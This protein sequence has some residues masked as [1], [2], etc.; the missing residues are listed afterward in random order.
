M[1]K[2][3]FALLVSLTSFSAVAE[4][5]PLKLPATFNID[6]QFKPVKP[7]KPQLSLN[8]RMRRG[9]EVG[10][11]GDNLSVHFKAAAREVLSLLEENLTN[12]QFNIEM[13]KNFDLPRFKKLIEEQRGKEYI[14]VSTDEEL[15]D[16]NS[17]V[18][19]A[20]NF[21]NGKDPQSSPIIDIAEEDL[22]LPLV[23]LNKD[24]W[25]RHISLKTDLSL[26]V[27]HELSPLIGMLDDN[28]AVTEFLLKIIRKK[29][30]LNAIQINGNRVMTM[31]PVE[32]ARGNVVDD[33]ELFKGLL[34]LEKHLLE[35]TQRPSILGTFILKVDIYSV[36]KMRGYYRL[37]KKEDSLRKTL[38]FAYPVEMEDQSIQ[39]VM[40]VKDE[41]F[42]NLKIKDR[43]LQAF[44]AILY[45]KEADFTQ[46]E[47][48]KII[49]LA[50]E[51]SSCID[52]EMAVNCWIPEVT[53]S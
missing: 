43:I 36:Q 34:E 16:K 39:Y 44:V 26:L 21:P 40:E 30:L 8:P 2:M 50:I 20:L 28:G 22:S 19:E 5:A 7:L 48:D 14:V 29:N 17:Q 24:A 18:K 6:R 25:E 3:I 33:V 35:K 11:G 46:A 9:D 31:P 27:F 38:T 51:I 15:F 13:P 12:P 32:G 45:L 53:R 42:Q 1:K 4:E 47:M 41:E 49:D 10:N 52:G 37:H 23:V